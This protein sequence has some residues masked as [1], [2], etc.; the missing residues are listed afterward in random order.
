M[1]KKSSEIVAR[2]SI[3]DAFKRGFLCGMAVVHSTDIFEQEQEYL[4]LYLSGKWTT[5]KFNKLLSKFQKKEY[6]L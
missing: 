4:K 1:K 6:R 2:I 3:E 5:K